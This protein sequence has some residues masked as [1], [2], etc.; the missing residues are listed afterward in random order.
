MS[1]LVV[2]PAGVVVASPPGGGGFPPPPSVS[3]PRR[4][5]RELHRLYGKERSGT[6]TVAARLGASPDKVRHDLTHHGIPIRR[7]GRPA[8]TPTVTTT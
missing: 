2:P 8:A 6:R 1:A 5:R 7:P 4:H 3:P